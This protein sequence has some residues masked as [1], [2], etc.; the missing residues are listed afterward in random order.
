[1]SSD[2]Y[3]RIVYL[4]LILASVSG[5]VMVEYRN[6]MGQ[7]LRTLMAWGLIFLGLGAGYGLW[8]DLRR[9]IMPMQQVE[10]GKMVVPRGPD[11][12]YHLQLD[13]N[14]QSIG[15]MVD[16]GASNIVL[17]PADA[18]SLGIDPASLRFL[19]SAETANGTVRTARVTL[20]SVTLGP[21]H[22]TDLR[23]YVNE[24]DMQGSLLGMD[25]L[26]LFS[27]SIQGDQMI[28]QR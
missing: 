15:F 3:L 13:I 26:G 5:W 1:M 23:A 8:H 25:Y 9:D 10:G 11:G 2:D 4:V 22:D 18:A 17:S 6:R 12:H 16:T 24:A 7:A 20:P 21:Y 19:G 14:G 27:I 28:L